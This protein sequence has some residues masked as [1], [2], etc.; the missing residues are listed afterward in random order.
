MKIFLLLSLCYII[1][2]IPAQD[3]NGPTEDETAT[4]IF[5]SSLI[6]SDEPDR[7]TSGKLYS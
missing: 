2:V 3:T 4:L 7:H 5:S 1:E 6:A